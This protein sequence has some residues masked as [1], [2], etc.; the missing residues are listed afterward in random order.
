MLDRRFRKRRATYEALAADKRLAPEV[1]A[2]G[3]WAVLVVSTGV[4]AVPVVFK[5]RTAGGEL[6]SDFRQ[7]KEV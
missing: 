6:V 2:A 1:V 5:A 7:L 3:S 4:V